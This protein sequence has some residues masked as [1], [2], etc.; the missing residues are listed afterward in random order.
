MFMLVLFSFTVEIDDDREDSGENLYDQTTHEPIYVN[1]N[2]RKL[3]NPIK[4]E[5]L[6]DFIKKAKEAE[7]NTIELEH[8][9]SVL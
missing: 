4:V 6:R 9:V 3:T 8:A 5:E 2:N 7:H 1:V